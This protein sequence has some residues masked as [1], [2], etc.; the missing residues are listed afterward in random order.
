MKFYS[1]LICITFSELFSFNVYSQNIS[2]SLDRVTLQVAI[3]QIEEKSEY[4]FFYN[5][6]LIDISKKVSLKSDN[7]NLKDIL[8]KLFKKTNIDFKVYK[9]QIVLFPRNVES[10]EQA[11]KNLL[12][13][14][15]EKS[16]NQDR[17]KKDLRSESVQN[18][19]SGM[20]RNEDNFLL[21]G[22]NVVIK[23]TNNGTLTDFNGN[24]K[25]EA[26]KGEILVFSY[27]G[28]ETKEVKVS[29]NIIN[30]ILKEDISNLEEVIVTGYGIQKKSRLTGSVLNV[31]PNTINATP[32]AAIQESI[33]GNIA[34]VQVTSSS[35]QPGA[36]PNVR[37][38]GIGSFES[39]F[40]LY[41]IDGFQTK[42]SNV[43]ASLNPGDIAAISVLKDAAATSIYGVRGANGVIVINTKS[44]ISGKTQISYSVQSGLSAASVANRFKPLNT[45]ELQELLV[46][47]VQNAG[48]REDDIDA[49]N[50][51]KDNGFNPEV[52]TDWYDLLTRDA[53]YQQHNLSIKGG[54]ENTKFYLS[55]GYFNQEGVILASQFERM[56]TRLKIDHKF[57]ERLKV[58]VNVSYNKTISKERPNSGFFANPVRAI[59]RI[60]PDISPYNEDG[61]FNFDFNGTQNP[62]AQAQKEIRKDID[63]RILAGA[64][65]SYRI[66]DGLTFESLINMNQ[67]FQD[68]YIRLS[69][70]FGDG[71]PSGRGE[72]DS[73]FLFS[74]LFRNLLKYNFNWNN[75][76]LKS[77]GG[78]ELQKV[79]DKFTD[80]TVENIPDGFE[81]LTNGSLFTLASTDKDQEG[82]NS[83]F[84]NAEYAYDN[85]YLVSGSIR[86]DGSSNLGKNNQFAVFWSVGLGWNI[87]NESFMNWIGF[88]D[89]LKLRTSYGINGNDP[90]T[91][92]FDLFSV[93]DYNGNPGLIFTS[94]G[95]PNIK[96][97]LNKAFN[98]GLDYSFF[99]SRVNGSLDWYTRETTDLL[100]LR[101]VS[102][103]NGD[104]GEP[105][106]DE[107]NDIADN[108]GSM[109]NTGFEF[110]ITTKNIISNDRG[111]SWITKFNFT[112]NKNKI[113][114]L[115]DGGEPIIRG[116]RITAVGEDIETF[117]LPIYAGVDPQNGNAL[118]YIDDSRTQ[119][120]SD[121]NNASRSIIGNA[122]PDFYAGLRNHFSYKG[123]ALD[124]QLYT[125]WGGL[126]YD[127][128]N[129][130]TNSDGARR[131]SSTGNV[132]RGTFERR[133]RKPGDITDVPAFVY[134]N[135]QSGSPAF[136]SSRFVYDGSYIRLR[137]VSLSYDFP[138][139]SINKIGLSNVKVYVKGNNLY[140]YIKDKRL[141]RDPEAGADGRLNQEIPISRTLF[142]GVDITF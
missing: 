56:N 28:F 129:R 25:I 133:W 86:R 57:N 117:F 43:V 142:L 135:G 74:W 30:V 101:P 138:L 22:V 139:T 97:E 96:W 14:I 19:V 35:G 16:T 121:Y 110:D 63:H 118:W 72:Q 49:L 12:D 3:D 18:L 95:N 24:Y 46:E 134:G 32:R 68:E 76:S 99:N 34:G 98:I 15:E 112:T 114:R 73:N 44:G 80:L 122:T 53:L 106:I 132:S 85:R 88:V 60:R 5:N 81:D 91:G 67:T 115:S 33:Q 13:Y 107:G 52:D 8:R 137:E 47:G 140:T 39:A 37:I 9:N 11:L 75:N 26:K 70:G 82:L 23:G 113:T 120:T 136:R 84:L 77:F 131:L 90:E 79:R 61:T 20:I 55:G 38:R 89:D 45:P 104:G 123:I 64:G 125:A 29:T 109:E 58:N 17:D 31:S 116:S 27:V 130:F 48:I 87:A 2:I 141:E 93:N 1:L 94:L 42:D 7:G 102:A 105:D 92:I 10:S 40:P 62:V 78:Y 51:L 41:V 108:I 100:R 127:T 50:F 119:I 6:S 66:I 103:A 36:T 54:G 21:P 65:S 126:V 124:F 128:W 83:V 71:R 69:S 59:Y 111:F 4:R